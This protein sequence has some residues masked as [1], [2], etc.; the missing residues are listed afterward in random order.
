MGTPSLGPRLMFPSCY[1]L[2]AG[3]KTASG[4]PRLH[5]PPAPST[6]WL[7]WVAYVGGGL[8]KPSGTSP[9]PEGAAGLALLTAQGRLQHAAACRA[10]RVL[11][12]LGGPWTEGGTCPRIG[13][14][15]D[16]QAA[17]QAKGA[18]TPPLPTEHMVSLAFHGRP[19]GAVLTASSL[20][21]ELN[22]GWGKPGR[23]HC[24]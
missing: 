15:E 19:R 3:P 11:R 7:R 12:S 8:R 1:L 6:P 22:R 13:A 5:G 10:P 24:G 16:Q 9:P 18:R 14:P 17:L 2:R 20:G 4:C 21:G 23:S